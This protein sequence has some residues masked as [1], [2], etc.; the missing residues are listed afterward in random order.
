MKNI[1]KD[2]KPKL[3]NSSV[4]N[5]LETLRKRENYTEYYI[6]IQGNT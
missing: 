2:I 5:A 1:E 3:T 4:K 6:K